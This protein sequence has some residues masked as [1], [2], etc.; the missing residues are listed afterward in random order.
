MMSN[1]PLLH[2]GFAFAG[3]LLAAGSL[4][5][6][7][8]SLGAQGKITGTVESV[9][10]EK[11]ISLRSP[12]SPELLQFQGDQLESIVF[13][14]SKDAPASTNNILYLKNG[15]VLPVTVEQL[16]DKTLS[17]ESPWS[18]KKS[19]ARTAID[20]LHFGTS[21]N[22]VLY[23]GPNQNEWQ[24]GRAWKFDNALVSQA[25]GSVHRKFEKLP[26]RY[27]LNFTVEWTGNAGIKCLFAST[28]ADG[29]GTADCYFLQ[30]NSGGLEL[31]RQ[32]TGSKKYTSLASFNDFTPDDV[33]DS[34]ME[35]EIRVDRSNRL[36]Q[37]AVNGKQMRNNIIDPAETGPMPSGNL[38]SFVSTSGTEDRH[39]ITDIRLSN[40]GS[41]SAEARMEK[42]TDTKRDVLFD[43]ESN[44]SSGTLKSITPG[45][46]LQVLFENPHDPSPKPLPG[47]KVAV[48]YFAGEN[49]KETPHPYRLKLHGTGTLHVDSFTLAD[50]VLRAK[51]PELGDLEIAA[52]LI[53]EITRI[54]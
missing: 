47:S 15:D 37:L 14:K 51:H 27:I 38:I 50:G 42:R 12:L 24:T 17:F 28:S 21:E 39:T 41:A 18:G 45:K 26:E 25:W 16:D 52:S 11:E 54:P 31:K 40:W 2:T 43:I 49:A 9:S 32:S 29:N 6:D 20:C 30:F 22:M 10:A 34:K 53:A 1:L 48:I 8:I 36:L 19:V 5:A 23:R 13:E 46:D 35:V 44:R 3:S 33:E 4:C 7:E